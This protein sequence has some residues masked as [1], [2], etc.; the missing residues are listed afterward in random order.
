M[1]LFQVMASYEARPY[2]KIRRH[3]TR[4]KLDRLPP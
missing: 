2:M 4:Q 1:N 3:L